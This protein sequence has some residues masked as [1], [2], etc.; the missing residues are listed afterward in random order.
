M[1]WTP[2]DEAQLVALRAMQTSGVKSAAYADRSVT[3]QDLGDITEAI[4]LLELQKA[5][6]STEVVASSS[7]RRT[8][9]VFSR[10]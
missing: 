3:Y 10:E 4:R 2:E 8:L 9:A 5:E 1:P 7:G 6:A